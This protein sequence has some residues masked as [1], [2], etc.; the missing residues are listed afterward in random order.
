LSIRAVNIS[1]WPQAKQSICTRSP[2]IAEHGAGVLD[3][4]AII[5]ADC[6]RMHPSTSIYGRCGVNFPEL[7]RWFLSGQA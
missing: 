2:V 3:L 1:A 5:A 6:P 4:C 7:S